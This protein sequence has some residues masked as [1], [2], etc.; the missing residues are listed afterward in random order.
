MRQSLQNMLR[1]MSLGTSFQL[2]VRKVNVVVII[3]TDPN[4]V[5]LAKQ[6][7]AQSDYCQTNLKALNRQLIFSL[8]MKDMS[9]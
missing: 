7:C 4:T 9:H 6:E 1:L 5:K 2:K 8:K 3:C